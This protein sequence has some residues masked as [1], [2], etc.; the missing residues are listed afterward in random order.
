MVSAGVSGKQTMGLLTPV[1]PVVS[2]T[3]IRAVLGE[4]GVQVMDLL[5]R[6][7]SAKVSLVGAT[8]PPPSIST[9]TA[10]RNDGMA[11]FVHADGVYRMGGADHGVA[12]SDD[13]KLRYFSGD[14][15]DRVAPTVGSERQPADPKSIGSNC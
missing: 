2:S 6:S 9:R 11:G 1:R 12:R 4:T 7:L 3:A 13:E 8:S 5:P 15:F 14:Y 10:P